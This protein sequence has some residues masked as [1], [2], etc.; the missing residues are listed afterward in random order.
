ME[1]RC[2]L[3]EMIIGKI[4]FNGNSTINQLGLILELTGVPS[5]E[6]ICK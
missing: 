3:E 2:N 4:L 5:K 6:D 1:F